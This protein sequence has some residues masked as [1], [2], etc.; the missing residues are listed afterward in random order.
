MR[1]FS[2]VF[3]LILATFSLAFSLDGFM[4]LN[5][6]NLHDDETQKLNLKRAKQVKPS[7][8]SSVILTTI[9]KTT[10]RNHK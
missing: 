5:E 6:K 3:L 1:F 4:D 10:T 2:L 7:T 9:S 8:T